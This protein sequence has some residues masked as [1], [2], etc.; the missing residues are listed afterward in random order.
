[1][2][3]YKLIIFDMDGTLADRD[4]A[5]LLPNVREKL[6]SLNGTH[7]MSIA[8]NQGGV[9]LRLQMEKEGWGEPE[10]FPTEDK[11]NA[12]I[13]LV[14]EQLGIDIYVA[15]CF[16]FKNKK[17]EWSPLPADGIERLVWCKTWR[18]PYPGMLFNNMRLED[19]TPEE[20]LMVGDSEDDKQAAANAGCDFQWA[21]EFF[22]WEKP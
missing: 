3:K 12:H 2:N 22:G 5:A 4:T 9:G 21:W 10:S 19:V 16:R 6:H 11:I 14:L 13:Q 15:K 20:T 7:K 1:M 18:K 8:T 17:G